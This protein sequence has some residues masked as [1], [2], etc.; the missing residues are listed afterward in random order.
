MEDPRTGKRVR[1]SGKCHL[2]NLTGGLGSATE[3]LRQ[4]WW[5]FL[6]AKVSDCSYCY[7]YDCGRRNWLGYV[8][9]GVIY[10]FSLFL[11]VS[12]WLVGCSG[13]Y[14]NYDSVRSY[15]SS[16]QNETAPDSAYAR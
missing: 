2:A 12:G 15:F 8:L 11:G 1:K 16:N 13:C 3:T 4:G 9:D 6:S 10:G 14:S 7:C 5:G